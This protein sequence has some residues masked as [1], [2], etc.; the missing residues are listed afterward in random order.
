M[1]VHATSYLAC[2]DL[3]MRSKE[4]TRLRANGFNR[5]NGDVLEVV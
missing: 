1:G 2:V 3:S 4:T 5:A